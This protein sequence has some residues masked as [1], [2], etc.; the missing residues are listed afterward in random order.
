MNT[1][2]NQDKEQIAAITSRKHCIVRASAGSGKTTV[3]SEH[4]LHLITSG[5]CA[6]SEI[7]ALTFTRKAAS[8]M[9][10]RIFRLLMEHSKQNAK[11][12]TQVAQFASATISTLDSYCIQIVQSCASYF[13]FGH[14]PHIDDRRYNEMRNYIAFQTLNIRKADTILRMLM[15]THTLRYVMHDVLCYFDQ[16]LPCTKEF[17]CEEMI[18]LQHA[19]LQQEYHTALR[20]LADIRQEAILLANEHKVMQE[21]VDIPMHTTEGSF[22][23]IHDEAC[24]RKAQYAALTI[25]GIPKENQALKDNIKEMRAIAE[26]LCDIAEYAVFFLKTSAL[27]DIMIEF[28]R[29]IN[30][31]KMKQGL[32]SYAN[33]LELSIVALNA[34][35]SLR[36]YL[37]NSIH[38]ILVDEFQDNNMLQ[39]NFL[40]LLAGAHCPSHT[41]N[42]SNADAPSPP[43]ASASR[44]SHTPNVSNAD[45]AIN[46][47]PCNPMHEVPFPSTEAARIF[48]VGD[49]KQSIYRFRGA[50][51]ALF[52]QMYTQFHNHNADCVQLH[53]N[54]RTHS[55]LLS[56][57]NS[58]C[59]EVFRPPHAPS[60]GDIHY[61]P[62][63]PH[64]HTDPVRTQ[65]YPFLSLTYHLHDT[66]SSHP[67]NAEYSEAL[68][69]AST[70]QDIVVQEKLH[71]FDN[72]TYRAAEYS[73][74]AI[75]LRTRTRSNV[76]ETTLQ[77]SGIPY[78]GSGNSAL[79]DYSV[80]HDIYNILFL[81]LYPQ[82][83]YI[84]ASVL[85]S[86]WVNCSDEAIYIILRHPNMTHAFLPID[87]VDHMSTD[88]Y[89]KYHSAVDLFRQLQTRTVSL[90]TLALIDY[91]WYEWG[92]RYQALLN[93]R[94]QQ[95]LEIYRVLQQIA[96]H[97]TDLYHF[98]NVLHYKLQSKTL[99]NKTATVEET[100]Y[101][102]AKTGVQLLT[103]HKAKGLEFPI[104]FLV[105][106]DNNIRAD[107][108][109]AVIYDPDLGYSATIDK[110]N[111]IFELRAAH[112][113]KRNDEELL[114]LLY[115]ALTRA[116]SHIFVSASEPTRI[117]SE[118]A[119][120]T[121]WHLIVN[122]V[123]NS[124][125]VTCQRAEASIA[126]ASSYSM[127]TQAAQPQ[128]AVIPLRM[129]H[130]SADALHAKALS[131]ATDG[132]RMAQ[133]A[134]PHCSIGTKDADDSYVQRIARTPTRTFNAT[135]VHISAT[136]LSN[137]CYHVATHF[138]AR[139]ND[140]DDTMRGTQMTAETLKIDSFLHDSSDFEAFGTL[141]HQMLATLIS[142]RSSTNAPTTGEIE[143]ILMQQCP[144]MF[145]NDEYGKALLDSC[146]HIVQLLFQ[147]PLMALLYGQ[148]TRLF[149]ERP[150]MLLKEFG[151]TKYVIHG[152][153]D[154]LC[155]DDT[156]RNIHV[157]DFKTD[158]HI[159]ITRH[160]GQIGCYAHALTQMYD[161]SI[162]ASVFYLRHGKNMAVDVPTA[163]QKIASQDPYESLR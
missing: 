137:A 60:A 114:R 107:I 163:I 38:S 111:I 37:S 13:S 66:E 15:N 36:T 25:R 119:P 104:V 148:H 134:A 77:N 75:L 135:T 150:F 72:G 78:Q 67:H 103:I 87:A 92:Y 158:T 142:T 1:H 12:R 109:N 51:A 100:D 2:P 22:L 159:D 10:Q 121:L 133:S 153:I 94:S 41:P 112:R 79:L 123:E 132:A 68:H 102:Q 152:I 45:G 86:G 29:R 129:L 127:P 108:R 147:S 54:Y 24:A 6:A 85:R 20:R 52:S 11:I 160:E 82:N 118:S 70:I 113:Q 146:C 156:S 19:Y 139:N 90:G 35:D 4:Y 106:S 124:A 154:V 18:V 126:D 44:P 7:I 59:T 120:T 69:I 49:D 76:I 84:F 21:I 33:I 40:Y 96:I 95:W 145:A 61:D 161:Y 99:W 80:A 122:A 58:I 157:I 50:N 53:T 3:L 65:T 130:S 101:V 141:C 8:E 46:I 151:A 125:A 32:F 73:D 149:C 143:H 88:D 93:A 23:E 97:H 155:I 5:Q 16:H 31:M 14:E 115:V 117:R 9:Y 17:D 144:H 30:I 28:Q 26:K 55:G 47:D 136:A 62:I 56:I 43:T 57:V 48:L 89:E 140:T 116:K 34:N 83:L 39:K 42:V 71:I 110:K 63:V 131:L 98:L 64:W 128:T 162:C 27:C 138:H 81:S 105:Q 91:L 74:I